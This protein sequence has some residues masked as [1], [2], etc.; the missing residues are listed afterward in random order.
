MGVVDERVSTGVDGRGADILL[1]WT[2][3]LDSTAGG[4]VGVVYTRAEP[5]GVTC[6]SVEGARAA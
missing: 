1:D 4:A 6:C 5:A 2:R 3:A